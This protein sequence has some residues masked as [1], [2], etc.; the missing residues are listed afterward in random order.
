MY[1][2]KKIL[3]L[4]ILTISLVPLHAENIRHFKCET[5]VEDSGY[6]LYTDVKIENGIAYIVSECIWDEPTSYMNAY[7]LSYR[8]DV[9]ILEY[10]D[11]DGKTLKYTALQF[12]FPPIVEPNGEI[13]RKLLTCDTSFTSDVASK[14]ADI[15][16]TVLTPSSPF[17]PDEP[18]VTIPEAL[19]GLW[20]F[21]E[22]GYIWITEHDIVIGDSSF[23]SQLL[24]PDYHHISYRYTNVFPTLDFSSTD[25]TF[26][27]EV[28]MLRLSPYCVYSFSVEDH[29]DNMTVTV[30]DDRG[31]VRS[32]EA[33]RVL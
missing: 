8:S 24:T 26:T 33:P 14:V 21:E 3:F 16:M 30:T 22:E 25:N 32:Q 1:S 10:T 29:A 27:I 5:Q 13:S 12:N 7:T 23:L 31:R 2:M 28:D 19:H 4:F 20:Y 9:L 18:E 6:A 17:S 15:E 11:K